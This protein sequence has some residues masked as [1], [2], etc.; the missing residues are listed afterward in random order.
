MLKIFKKEPQK[1]Q[2]E[3]ISNI[4]TLVREGN[5]LF[6]DTLILL[7]ETLAGNLF[8]AETIIVEQNGVLSGNITSKLCVVSGTINGNI[9]STDQMDIK[10]TAVIKGNIRSAL[11]N[12]E[13]GAVI[14]GCVTIA[15]DKDTIAAFTKIKGYSPDEYMET[16]PAGEPKLKPRVLP[17]INT[18]EEKEKLQDRPFQII[19]EPDRAAPHQND[20]TGE[21][22]NTNKRWW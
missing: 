5:D 18:T 4:S 21:D 19:H 16:Q 9:I 17:V 6:S 15:Q 20:G 1:E 14:N 11:I 10:S 3:S 2:I 12:I 22:E 8:C 13:P 7:D